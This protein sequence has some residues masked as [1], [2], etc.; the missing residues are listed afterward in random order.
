[1][2]GRDGKPDI[3]KLQ[4]VLII[5]TIALFAVATVI[6]SIDRRIGLIACHISVSLLIMAAPIRILWVGK[7]FR[8]A[9]ERRYRLLAYVLIAIIALTAI[10]RSLF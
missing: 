1:M 6:Y 4:S 2:P 5:I 10:L 9:G 8:E 7:L 3:I